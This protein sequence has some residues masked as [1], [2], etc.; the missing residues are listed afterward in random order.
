MNGN[1]MLNKLIR[2]EHNISRAYYKLIM[3]EM[4]I[5]D[6]N[7]S[8]NCICAL[9][10][11]IQNEDMILQDLDLDKIIQIL[12]VFP[13]DKIQEDEYSRA[14]MAICDK[15]I[16]L[17]FQDELGIDMNIAHLYLKNYISSDFGMKYR[18]NDWFLR[19]F[20][21][22]FKKY[23]SVMTSIYMNAIRRMDYLLKNTKTY[24]VEDMVLAINLNE[25]FIKRK[26][27]FYFSNR[28]FERI[29]LVWKYQ[30]ENFPEFHLIEGNYEN[31]YF[32]ECLIII[33]KLCELSL[34]E[35]DEVNIN[36]GLFLMLCFEEMLKYLKKDNLTR[37]EKF[38][39]ELDEKYIRSF[40]GKEFIEKL[41]IRK[42]NYK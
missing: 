30:P 40:Y 10:E 29:A 23:N 11:G 38:T 5:K 4:D 33:K 32:N 17:F 36:R 37:L 12:E 16:E 26:Y 28:F 27:F 19:V 22:D 41:R 13:M 25:D 6:D 1:D 7:I 21:H 39:K 14:Y 35:M 9:R 24:N 42:K 20:D 34:N 3:N 2:V 8:S 15:N 18:L 31:I